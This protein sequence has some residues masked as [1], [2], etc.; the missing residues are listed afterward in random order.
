[1]K[2]WRDTVV[3]LVCLV[4]G[5]L[6]VWQPLPTQAQGAAP[7]KG[8]PALYEFGARLLCLLQRDGKESWRH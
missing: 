2:F 4:V 5:F 1:M 3:G 8:K 6:V 7:A